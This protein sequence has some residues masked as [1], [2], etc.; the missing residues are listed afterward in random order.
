MISFIIQ[1]RA[2]SSRLPNKILLPF[3]EDKCILQLLVEKLKNVQDTNIIIATSENSNCDGIEIL[4]KEYGVCCYRGSENDV[5]ERFILAAEKFSANKIVRVCSDNPFL[6]LQAIRQLVQTAESSNSADY[7]SF[8]VSGKPSITTHY[9]FWTEYVTLEALKKIRNYA[10]EQLYYEHVT[11]YIY[12]HPSLFRVKWLQTPE[13]LGKYPNIRLTIDTEE[14]FMQ[15][16]KIYKELCGN[17]SYPSIS[18]IVCYLQ[19]HPA[20][21]DLMQNQIIQNT[22]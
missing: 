12:T 20:Y 4:A 2:G 16:R 19:K 17:N 10:K 15:V 21:F 13:I 3:Y 14:D 5:L 22:K 1:A 7:I 9:G 6:E 18:D 11:N 8:K